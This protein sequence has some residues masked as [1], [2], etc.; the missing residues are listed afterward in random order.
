[1]KPYL[2]DAEIISLYWAQDERAVAEPS[3]VELPPKA[4]SHLTG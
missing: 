4:S 2:T 3:R 1:M